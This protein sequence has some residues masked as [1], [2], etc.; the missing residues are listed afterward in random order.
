MKIATNVQADY[1]GGIGRSNINLLNFLKN[2]SSG[3]I[4]IEI[5]TKVHTQNSD[6]FKGLSVD[7][8]SHHIINIHD[9]SLRKNINSAKSI[10][11]LEKKYRPI[12]KIIK[13]ILEKDRP[14]VLFLNGT[15]YLPWLI[16]IAAH[17]LKIP[18]VLRYAGLYTKETAHYKPKSRKMLN[19]IEKSF[20]NR[21]S[22]FIFPS[23][24]AKEA[25][26]NEVIGKEIKNASVIPNPLEINGNRD[27]LTGGTERRIAAVG[28]WDEIKNFSAF[29]KIHKILKNQKW[30]HEAS[31]VTSKNAKV[32]YMPKSINRLATM[33]HEELLNFYSSQGIIISPSKFETF[34]NVAMEAVCM[35]IPVLVSENMG[36]AEI[37][38]IAG[39]ENMVMPFDDLK[40]VAERVKKLCGQHILPRQINNVRKFLNP[41]VINAEIMSI[42]REAAGK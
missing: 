36:C 8:F 34:G 5:N 9:I 39:L 13:S 23:H 30:R 7:W 35:G 12:I 16:S 33:T 26:E 37:L 20:Q 14:D 6:M 27:V 21:V 31:F 40:L 2:K 17:E 11:D 42:L 22:H 15:Y 41:D 19:L 29:F 32:R 18:V 10:K 3:V 28:R 24:L 25:V 38:K 4:G 1:L